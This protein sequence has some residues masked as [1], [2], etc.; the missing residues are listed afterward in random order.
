MAMT[1]REFASLGGQARARKLTKEKRRQIAKLAGIAS[2]KARQRRR[3]GQNDAQNDG[4]KITTT[5]TKG[6]F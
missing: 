6:I 3:L 2:G 5:T 1:Q 4:E